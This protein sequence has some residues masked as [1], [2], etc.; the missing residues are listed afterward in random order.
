MIRYLHIIRDRHA[1][2]RFLGRLAKFV[3]VLAW[4][5]PFVITACA[6]SKSCPVVPVYEAPRP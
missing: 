1:R 6:C 4:S 5:L 3:V 2:E